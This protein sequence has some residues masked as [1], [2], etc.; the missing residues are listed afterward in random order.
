MCGS[1]FKPYEVGKF[2]EV[3][4][5]YARLHS[6]IAWWP[7]MGEAH[8]D[9]EIIGFDPLHYHVDWR[10]VSSRLYKRYIQRARRGTLEEYA[11][12][13]MLMP[14]PGWNVR[15]IEES[16]STLKHQQ[17]KLMCKRQFSAYPR[18]RVPWLARL[19]E[20]HAGT[21]LKRNVCPHRGYDLSH[22]PVVD[23]IVTCP[24]HGLSWNVNTGS[25]VQHSPSST[26]IAATPAAGA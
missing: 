7:V 24:L 23:G 9:S 5:V 21:C 19:S 12:P 13:L 11:I 10:F 1:T 8:R 4:C 17:M 14:E 22:E 16:F 18:S 25:C 20:H 2:Y 3:H 6:D 26:S 15:R